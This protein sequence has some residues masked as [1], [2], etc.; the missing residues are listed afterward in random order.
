MPVPDA[1]EGCQAT[2]SPPMVQDR[3]RSRASAST[4]SGK[5]W[6]RSLPGPAVE[7]HPLAFLAGDDPDV[8]LN[9]MHPQIAGRRLGG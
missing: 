1:I 2:A 4:M 9:L 3:E 7:L 6:V 8:V 5:R